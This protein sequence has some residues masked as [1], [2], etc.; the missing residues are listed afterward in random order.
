MNCSRTR[1]RR[2][3]FHGRKEK[4]TYGMM[5][6]VR[7]QAIKRTYVDGFGWR[8]RGIDKGSYRHEKLTRSRG[9]QMRGRI[10]GDLKRALRA[11]TGGPLGENPAQPAA[12]SEGS[13]TF[14]SARP[15]VLPQI[16][17]GNASVVALLQCRPAHCVPESQA[18][19]SL[20][21]SLQLFTDDNQSQTPFTLIPESFLLLILPVFPPLCAHIILH[22]FLSSVCLAS[23]V[24]EVPF[25]SQ[26]L[27]RTAACYFTFPL[28]STS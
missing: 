23:S 9:Q 27:A 8:M 15:G 5:F 17:R 13:G 19:L 2:D 18:T 22:S 6:W 14:Q 26:P 4:W 24:V 1:N 25:F 7:D 3:G 21:Y 16:N 10:P 11:A 12:G 28:A 20:I